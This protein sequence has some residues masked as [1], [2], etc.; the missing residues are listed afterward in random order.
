MPYSPKPPPPQKDSSTKEIFDYLDSELQ[1]V[2]RE[3]SENTGGSSYT[4]PTITVSDTAPSSPAVNDL[5][6]DTN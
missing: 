5:W 6:V 1:A 2:A 3:L 4:G